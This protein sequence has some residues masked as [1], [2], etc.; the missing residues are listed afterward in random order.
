[1]AEKED[2][3]KIELPEFRLVVSEAFG[4][5]QKGEIIDSPAEISKIL[6]SDNSGHVRKIS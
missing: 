5:Y 2:K 1:M 3:K 6:S 4:N